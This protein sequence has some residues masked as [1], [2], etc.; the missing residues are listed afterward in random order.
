MVLVFPLSLVAWAAHHYV[1]YRL[2]STVADLPFWARL[3]G[4]LVVGEV[5]F[6]WGHRWSHQ[7]PFL[8]RFHA[9]H[10][11]AEHI[12]WL[13]NT[14][15]HPVDM[16][17]TRLCG[18]IPLYVLGFIQPGS[19]SANMTPVAIVLLGAVWG[20]F[21][22]ANLRW[23]FGWLEWLIATPA[24]HHWHHTKNDHTNRNYASTLPWL[25]RIFGTFYMPKNQ[26]PAHY[27]IDATTPDGLPEQL[28]HP[29]LPIKQPARQ[30][31]RPNLQVD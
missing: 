3:A 14:H 15:A 10:H 11:S 5:G 13:V 26:W 18:F 17:F 7:I 31:M 20:F 6:Y 25:D 28:M 23:R 29:F 9:I 27:G 16:I 19:G 30:A 24:F 8:W 4:A 2:H 22:H 21:I 12:D 1:P